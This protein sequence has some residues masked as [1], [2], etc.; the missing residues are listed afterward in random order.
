MAYCPIASAYFGH[1]GH[2]YRDM[3]DAG[4]NVCFG[5]D[6]ILCQPPDEAEPLGILPQIRFLRR[7][8]GVD[9]EVLLHMATLAGNRQAAP[10]R[11]PM[12]SCIPGPIVELTD[13][14]LI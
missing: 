9:S 7:R 13:T 14:R 11:L 12:S 1:R 2:R 8:D 5:T 6:S 10:L 4:V 3:L